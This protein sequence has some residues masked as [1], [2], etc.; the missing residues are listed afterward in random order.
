M[1]DCEKNPEGISKPPPMAKQ[2][3]VKANKINRQGIMDKG[4]AMDFTNEVFVPKVIPKSDKVKDM[5]LSV[6][7]KNILFMSYT[8]EEHMAIID[9]FESIKYKADDVVIRQGDKGR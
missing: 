2:K 7:S 8:K 5:L 4:D 6:V 1:I 3:S 9:A